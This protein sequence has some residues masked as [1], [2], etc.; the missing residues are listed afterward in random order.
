MNKCRV[1]HKLTVSA[2]HLKTVH[3]IIHGLFGM[4]VG[5]VAVFIDW[6]DQLGQPEIRE[7]LDQPEILEE[8]ETLETLGQL[9][10][11]VY[12]EQQQIQEQLVRHGTPM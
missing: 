3:T 2:E 12:L 8:R 4:L 6:M 10:T 11:R 7:I 9:E 5:L 1:S